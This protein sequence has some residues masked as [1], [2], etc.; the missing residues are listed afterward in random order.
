MK[1]RHAIVAAVLFAGG[2]GSS[3]GSGGNVVQFG[4]ALG[5]AYNPGVLAVHVGDTVTWEGDFGTHPLVSGPS[6]GQADG[7]FEN[8]AGARFSFTFQQ[9]GT[10]PYHCNVHCG[11]GMQGV[12]HVE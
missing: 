4:G 10:Y 6:C 12:I 8:S 3:S 2:C 9:A 7:L 1:S 11:S 5:L